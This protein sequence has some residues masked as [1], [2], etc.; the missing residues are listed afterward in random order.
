M[1]QS[2][3]KW[4]TTT[5]FDTPPQ[6]T[7][8]DDSTTSVV[9]EDEEDHFHIMSTPIDNRQK[10]ESEVYTET[11]INTV[12]TSLPI[13]FPL[14]AYLTYDDIAMLFN[15]F[16]SLLDTN[17]WVAVDGG[18]YQAKVIA[19]AING[20][21]VPAVSILFATLISNTFST[22]RQ[23]QLDIRT[24]IN[25]EAC[26]LRVLSSI[27]DSFP[28]SVDQEKCRTYLVHY[29]SRLISESKPSVK[30][31]SLEFNGSMESEMNG[32]LNTLNKIVTNKDD[33][34]LCEFSTINPAAALVSEAY[35]AL[36]RLNAERSTRISAL[37]ATY[38][39]LHYGILSTLA[40]SI[41]IAFLIETNQ[42]ILMF[43]NAIQLRLLWTILIGT[44]SALGVVCYD[45]SDPFYGSYE[46][47]NSLDQLY[48]IRDAL[49]VTNN[50][51][52]KILLKNFNTLPHIMN[53]QSRGK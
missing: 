13:V 10:S 28:S 15:K 4:T 3:T 34:D 39:A 11:T 44:F 9:E 31:N 14:L 1:K 27:V 48:T 18:A 33:D 32:F 20:I 42:D 38:P 40:L 5:I 7:R 23:R 36:T 24:S 26:E 45:L 35:S 17:T 37:L 50:K 49:S 52:F 43:L 25:R 19:P 47:S 21:I 53:K 6:Q 22:L 30:Y 51:Q 29:T 16:I 8:L 12:L 46:I 41:C 2:P